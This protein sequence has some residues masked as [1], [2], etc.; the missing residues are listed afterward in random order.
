MLFKISF[1]SDC[2]NIYEPMF[3]SDEEDDS[4][5]LEDSESEEY[6][7]ESYG[8]EE[9]EE[10]DEEQLEYKTNEL[11]E[12]SKPLEFN[13][14]AGVSPVLHH[15]KMVNYLTETNQEANRCSISSIEQSS[16]EKQP[17]EEEEEEEG[18]TRMVDEPD[19]KAG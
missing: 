3:T 1:E 13:R 8:N 6:G 16:I 5:N 11:S 12:I 4:V 19:L 14:N 17:D 15:E 2:H 10:E 9:E 7:T 18:F